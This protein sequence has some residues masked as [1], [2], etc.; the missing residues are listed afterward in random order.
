M[1]TFFLL[2]LAPTWLCQAQDMPVSERF[3]EMFVSS[4]VCFLEMFSQWKG[5]CGA[6]GT[7]EPGATIW[8]VTALPSKGCW[9][10]DL[11]TGKISP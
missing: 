10:V 7:W 4:S 8:P 11:A 2:L 3:S 5:W 1:N 9:G 6:V